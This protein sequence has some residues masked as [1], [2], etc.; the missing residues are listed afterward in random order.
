MYADDVC[1][2]YTRLSIGTMHYIIIMLEHLDLHYGMYVLLSLLFI[3]DNSM[4]IP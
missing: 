2:V 4:V 1:F 3:G